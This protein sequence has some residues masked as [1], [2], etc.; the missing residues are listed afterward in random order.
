[1]DEEAG[2][3]RRRRR[4]ARRWV[5]A[6]DGGCATRRGAGRHRVGGRRVRATG[7]AETAWV[8]VGRCVP[9][10]LLRVDDELGVGLLCTP[11]RDARSWRSSRPVASLAAASATQAQRRAQPLSA[12]LLMT[13]QV[14]VGR[15][16][17]PG[18]GGARGPAAATAR[19]N[20][21]WDHQ[22]RRTCS[23]R[24]LLRAPHRGSTPHPETAPP[25]PASPEMCRRPSL[26][27]QRRAAARAASGRI[28]RG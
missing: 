5:G 16:R 1:M 23:G 20:G 19:F 25:A 27:R 7:A 6:V 21:A 14:C 9:P 22:S 13:K 11:R 2:A 28:A 15:E 26:R 12:Q 8:P 24:P 17:P 18:G 4:G 10:Y 3:R